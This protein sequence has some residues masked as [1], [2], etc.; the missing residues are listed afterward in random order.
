MRDRSCPAST[1]S[2]ARRTP[3]SSRSRSSATPNA[4]AGCSRRS[5]RPGRRSRSW[6]TRWSGT[7]ATTRTTPSTPTSATTT[8]SATTTGASSSAP[9]TPA[10]AR[11]ASPRSDLE[12]DAQP[13]LGQETE[14]QD[15]LARARADPAVKAEARRERVL[16][17]QA[18]ADAVTV[19]P[20]GAVVA[21]DRARPRQRLDPRLGREQAAAR[22]ALAVPEPDVPGRRAV[23][24]T[25][26]R[27]PLVQ[28]TA[29]EPQ[30]VRRRSEQPD[31]RR[32]FAE[33]A[34]ERAVDA[35]LETQPVG[36]Q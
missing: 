32:A 1:T 34:A 22:P 9:S 16:P 20:Q 4:G 2:S 7:S 31:Q 25:I 30:P 18:E 12:G 14:L 23:H 36:E 26:E 8:S 6:R 28:V 3:T 13:H 24:Q 5:R 33:H 21:G 15:V 19:R 11:D 10:G 17:T 29:A 27:D 35:R